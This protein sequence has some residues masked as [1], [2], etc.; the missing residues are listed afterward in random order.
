VRDLYEGLATR[1]E[2]RSGHRT[3]DRAQA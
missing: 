3:P 1:S 2:E